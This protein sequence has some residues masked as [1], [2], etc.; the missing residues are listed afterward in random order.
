MRNARI[1]PLRAAMLL[2]LALLTAL[3]GGA[4]AQDDTTAREGRTFLE[5]V[6]EDALSGEGRD[7]QVIGFAGALSAR[8]TVEQITFSDPQGTWLTIREAVLDWDRAAL[9]GGRLDITS[10]GAK[11]I[12]LTRPPAP[13][14]A[15][16]PPPEASAP[17]SLPELPVSVNIGSLS[18][19]K[20]TLGKAV[21]GQRAVVALSGGLSLAGG[22]GKG[23]LSLK[24]ID[25]REGALTLKAG[26]DNASRVLSL[27]LTAQ[28]AADGIAAGLLN[29]PGRPSI[30]LSA[31]GTGPITGYSADVSLATDGQQ[32]L[33]G[34]VTLGATDTPQDES[35]TAAQRFALDIGGD[36]A[37]LFAPEYR[38]FFGRNIA[39]QVAGER[40]ADGAMVLEQLSLTAKALSLQGEA[41]IA[42]DG[43]PERLALNGRI[44]GQDGARV[45]LPAS[46]PRT[47]LR[48]AQIDLA[49]DAAK[50]QSWD[51]SLRANGLTRPD[52]SLAEA[53]VSATGTLQ[54][55][56]DGTPGHVTG[57]VDA[58]LSG[59]RPD[60]PALAKAIGSSLSA[61]TQAYWTPGAPV[62]LTGL[63]LAGADYDLS[64]DLSL[65]GI[66]D[67][68]EVELRADLRA[69]ARDLSRFAA[70]A[71]RP[72]RGSAEMSLRGTATP[73]SGGFDMSIA[74]KTRDLHTGIGTLDPLLAGSTS[75]AL[76][77]QRSTDGIRIKRLELSSDAVQISGN[78][79]LSAAQGAAEFSARLSD[80]GLIADGV[81]GPANM[82]LSATRA[83]GPW[84]ITLD[85]DGP[86]GSAAQANGT[87]TQDIAT[88]DLSI[89]GQA[90]LALANAQLSPRS[91]SGQAR[92]D[93]R[94]AGPPALSSLSG[95][96][97][98][99]GA[100]LTLPDQR[101][102]LGEIDAQARLSQGRADLNVSSALSSG[103][104]VR[105]SGPV[106]LSPPFDADLAVELR[107]AALSDPT[108]F[109]TT[110][111][112]DL[113][114]QGPLAG[115]ARIGGTI[116]LGDV[117]LR[118]PDTS[119]PS[120][121]D[122]PGLKHRSE[123]ADVRR[124]RSWAGV[125]GTPG[126]G[127][128]AATGP[129]YP[130]D[131]LVRAPARIFVRGR[132][133][134]AELGGQI[135]LTGT[136]TNLVPQ[137]RFDLIRGRLDILGRRL[138]LTEGLVNLQGAFDP[139]INFVAE[140]QTDGTSVRIGLTGQASNPELELTSSPELPRDEV[141][142][143]LLFGRGVTDISPFQALRLANALRTLSG[144]G[145][146]GISERL[147]S[148]TGLDNLDVTTDANGTAQ[149]RAGKYISENIYTDVVVDTQGQT[150]INLNLTVSPNITA[151][152]RLGSEGDTGLGVFYERDY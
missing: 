7:V 126:A 112:G 150:E 41:R 103:G 142:S 66:E 49:F 61:R 44:G 19:E 31:K 11:S 10:L 89:T 127:T 23:N 36:I 45:L 32:R 2:A 98:T 56:S 28:E 30:S 141:L 114:V 58:R 13:T 82:T 1:I 70:L 71:D 151:R 109:K 80:L 57:D 40:G 105:L 94:L 48:E 54:R 143:L 123:P 26:Y 134:D 97:A 133:L 75:L 148:G 120:Y 14:K 91:L 84:T 81:R 110:A 136:T 51:M 53:T 90:P 76:D 52:L 106:T 16:A 9:L 78:G 4:R 12:T 129:A 119:G 50:G 145:G 25:G 135:R 147:R 107:R 92:F 139:Y 37:P 43:W 116:T 83:T 69:Q 108:L 27:D 113:R 73:V 131:L 86:G 74:G 68:L 22:E 20:V 87:I 124:T 102:A 132:G 47:S 96:V 34:T 125:I 39:L 137:G 85:A 35:A 130:V 64:G 118:V 77:A 146:A 115:G 152:G 140:T 79:R 101:L 128:A 63:S 15:Q 88:A 104:S 42:A 138:T 72:L 122:L 65:K 5:G 29:L 21:L 95:T 55:A 33:A 46:G 38:E 144:Q 121:G 17:F 111:N 99:A 6:L 24:R 62:R 100:R 117:E 93:L 60:D 149:A 3:P 18:A 59:L 8:A 67:A